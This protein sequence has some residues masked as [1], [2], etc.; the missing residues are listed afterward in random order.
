MSKAQRIA[1]R[2][3]EAICDQQI[4]GGVEV[5]SRSHPDHR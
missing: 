3:S 5:R 1:L 2:R 4:A